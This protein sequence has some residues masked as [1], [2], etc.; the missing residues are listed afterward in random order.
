MAYVYHPKYIL[1]SDKK[2]VLYDKDTTAHKNTTIKDKLSF[3]I[4]IYKQR[5]RH[6]KPA[7]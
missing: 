3:I 5:S 7:V 2:Q 6:I 1:Y 4:N